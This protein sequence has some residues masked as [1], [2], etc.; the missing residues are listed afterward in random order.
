MKA[1]STAVRPQQSLAPNP[2]ADNKPVNFKDYYGNN[3]E[4]STQIV[5]QYLCPNANVSD[6]EAFIF[7]E[8]CKY[9][10]LNPW[11]RGEVYPIKY[12]SDPLQVVIGKETFTKRAQNHPKFRGMKAGIVVINN[13]GKMERRVG[14]IT[15]DGETIVGGWADVHVG[16]YIEPIT[17]EVSFRERCKYKDGKPASKWASS[18]A[19]MI[20]KCALVAALREAFP[21][22]LGGM[23]IA[24]E[25]GY[26]ETEQNAAPV[27]PNPMDNAMD[28]DYT[29]VDEDGDEDIQGN[30][31]EED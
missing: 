16:G 18:P 19:L 30:F 12:G 14:E 4:L 20:R 26:E 11:T 25:M 2:V 6:A 13:D 31:F 5:K 29:P 7:I 15:L 23:Y 1:A 24:E 27:V 9:Q 10:G 28:A 22:K 8:L 3:V 21:D 17:A